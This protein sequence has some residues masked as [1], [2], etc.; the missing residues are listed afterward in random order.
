MRRL[1]NLYPATVSASLMAANMWKD[2]LKNVESDNNNI[3]VRNPTR[4]FFLQRNVT[5]FLNKPC[6]FQCIEFTLK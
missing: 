4:L 6:N 3:F 2:S 1:Y 5:Y